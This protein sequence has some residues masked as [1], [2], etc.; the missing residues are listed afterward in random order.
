MFEKDLVTLYLDDIRKYD[1]LTREEELS[2]LKKAQNGDSEAKNSLILS[3]LRLVVSIAK[4][5]SVR[6]FT[7]TDL[8]S[9]GNIGLIHSIDKFDT[10][11]GNR[12][13]TYAVWWIKQSINKAIITKGREIRIPSYKYEIVGKVNKFVVKYLVE[14]G[15]YPTNQQISEGFNLSLEKVEKLL[16]EFQDILSLNSNIGEDICLE[17]TIKDNENYTIEDALIDKLDKREILNMVG[18]LSER[19]QNILKMRYGLGGGKSFTLEEVGKTFSITR[20]RVRQIEKRTL[21]KLKEK[22]TISV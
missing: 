11:L 6:G 17:D 7:L 10:E 13:S 3:N 22:Y 16:L 9:E 21:E 19:E 15:T 18:T 20:E 12:F 8:I 14:N 4:S 1:I 5:Y 2:L